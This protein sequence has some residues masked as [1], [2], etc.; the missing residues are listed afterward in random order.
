MATPVEDALAE[1]IAELAEVAP[2]LEGLRDFE[3]LNLQQET[4]IEVRASIHAYERRVGLLEDAKAA[5]E[6]LLEDGHPVIPVREV[7]PEVFADLAD[8]RNTIQAALGT[9]SAGAATT[10]GLSIG[11]PEPK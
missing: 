1:I 10:L 11:L 4:L 2:Q 6:R 9:F 3:R 7:A 5:L 8:N